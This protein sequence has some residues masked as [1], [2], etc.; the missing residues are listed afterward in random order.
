[1]WRVKFTAEG[2]VHSLHMTRKTSVPKNYKNLRYV[3]LNFEIQL[4][5][6]C[7]NLRWLPQDNLLNFEGVL[8]QLKRIIWTSDSEYYHW[9]TSAGEVLVACPGASKQAYSIK[10]TWRNWKMKWDERW[11]NSMKWSW[12]KVP[13]KVEQINEYLFSEKSKNKK[14]Q[15][16]NKPRSIPGISVLI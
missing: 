9:Q 5:K 2:L 11:I 1:M 12:F 14:W 10:T 6:I 15:W 4:Q 13:V 3:E 7:K 8:C 16:W